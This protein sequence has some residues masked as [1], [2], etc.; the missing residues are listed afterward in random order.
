M[1][2]VP[3]TVVIA[4]YGLAIAL[5]GCESDHHGAEGIATESTCPTADVPTYNS[6][7]KD[8]MESYCT[9]CHS[10]T[11]SGDD[12]NDAPAG[13]DFDSLAGVVL[14]ANHIDKYAAAG[15]AGMNEIMPKSDPRPTN[16]ERLRLGQWLACE[17]AATAK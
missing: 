1:R 4:I 15:P 13:H 17:L 14:V 11:L 6:F 12:R 16:A 3:K 5:G 9:R 8:F 7:G 2:Q 10:S